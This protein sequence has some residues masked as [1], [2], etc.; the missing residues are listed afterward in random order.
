MSYSRIGVMTSGGDAPGMNAAV[1]A[2]V[3]MA[4]HLGVEVLGIEDGF[5]GLLDGRIGPLD[6]HR[7][8]GIERQGGT[9]LG[10]SRSE[11][12]RTDQGLDQ[13]LHQLDRENVEALIVIGGEGSLKGSFRLHQRGFPLVVVPA[14][15]D[16]NAGGTAVAIGTD[17]AI[18]TALDAIDKLK[19]TAA[20]FHRAFV[21]EVMGRD[22][23][24]IALQSAIAAGVDLVLVPE[25]PFEVEGVVQRMKEVRAS[26]KTH[27]ILL[28]AEGISP[29]ASEISQ[30]I[31]DR[32]DTGF[33]SRLTILGH[34]Q[35]GGSPTAFDR[36]L[37]SQLGA[38]A[39]EE[40]AAGRAGSIVGFRSMMTVTTPIETAVKEPGAFSQEAYRFAEILAG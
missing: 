23:G 34:I 15:I 39:V 1:R 14:T 7:V 40:L 11:K 13:A 29:T 18:N 27:F 12:F 22:S 24:W 16:N 35:R 4:D 25:V 32:G 37:A 28:A 2:V 31:T 38:R 10:T 19:D 8:S 9:I 3:R 33:E 20:A 36:L 21:V 26:G 6:S 5:Q 17:T 30:F